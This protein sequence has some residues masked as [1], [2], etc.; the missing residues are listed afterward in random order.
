MTI[1][2]SITAFFSRLWNGSDDEWE[3]HPWTDEETE[4]R[5]CDAIIRAGFERDCI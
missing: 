1:W 3:T 5:I 2:Q 4:S